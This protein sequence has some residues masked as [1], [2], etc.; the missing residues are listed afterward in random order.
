MARDRKA[1]APTASAANRGGAGRPASTF[2][3]G[4]LGI[5]FKLQIAFGA[6]AAMTVVAA[7]IAIMSFSTTE[8]GLQSV[9][10][11]DVPV[12]TAALRLSAT[13]GEI[14]AAASR[15]VSAKSADEQKQISALIAE[16]N[17][18]LKA[19]ME[20]VRSGGR[21]GKLFAA[22]EAASQR[23]DSNLKALETAIT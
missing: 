9:A 23:L 11:S 10:N 22:V 16:R 5:R 7:G 21:A 1:G 13:S 15:F 3:L 8:S 20:R 19:T 14:S 17:N 18:A 12:M 2:R 6:V 4:A